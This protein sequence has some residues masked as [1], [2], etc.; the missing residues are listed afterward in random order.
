MP[1]WQ[2]TSVTWRVFSGR[3]GLV[4]LGQ[5]LYRINFLPPGQFITLE[6]STLVHVDS[7]SPLQCPPHWLI[8]PF[9]QFLPCGFLSESA[10]YIFFN[11][12][13]VNTV[14]WKFYF[15]WHHELVGS[16]SSRVDIFLIWGVRSGRVRSEIWRDGLIG[17]R[18]MPVDNSVMLCPQ[19]KLI[20]VLPP[21]KMA[22][23]DL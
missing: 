12:V 9:F 11:A 22:R 7:Q 2:H 17:S 19:R 1:M 8:L 5:K 3:L 4:W 14:F 21:T 23:R 18:K 20:G 13:D 15:S 6:R 10:E 16:R